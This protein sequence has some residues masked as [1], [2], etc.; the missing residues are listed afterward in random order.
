MPPRK[1]ESAPPEAATPLPPLNEHSIIVKQDPAFPIGELQ[2]YYRNPNKGDVQLIRESIDVNGVFRSVVANVG[3]LTGRPNEILAGNHTWL[4]DKAEG[5]THIPVDFV[6]VDEKHAARIVAVDNRA[7]E[8]GKRDKDLLKELLGDLDDLKG[9]GYS[10]DDLAKLMGASDDADTGPQ[11][12]DAA[13]AVIID[14]ED[15][16]QQGDLLG[17][18]EERG[19]AARPLMM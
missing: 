13:Y 9:S 5:K 11:L 15:E 17:E 19:L 12:D 2:P 14:C 3:T 7:A 1:R 6:D 16:V 4:A 18:F 10:D 8:K